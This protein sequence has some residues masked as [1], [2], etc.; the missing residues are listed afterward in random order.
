MRLQ[1]GVPDRDTLPDSALPAMSP[2]FQAEDKAKGAGKQTSKSPDTGN[3]VEGRVDLSVEAWSPPCVMV[4]LDGGS[5]GRVC[6]TE[7]SDQ[8]AWKD[9]PVQR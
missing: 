8:E 3:I 7:I 9:N 5:I 2:G 6:V 4:R 1:T